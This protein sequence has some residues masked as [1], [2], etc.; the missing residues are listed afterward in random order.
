M[1]QMMERLMAGMKAVQHKWDVI[2]NERKAH[3]Q[4]MMAK[5]DA[6]LGETKAL[7]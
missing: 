4:E 6:W 1:E 7:P 2:E 3:H 5:M